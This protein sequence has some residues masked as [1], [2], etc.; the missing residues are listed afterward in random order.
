[1][2]SSSNNTPESPFPK[3]GFRCIIVLTPV[4]VAFLSI[5]NFSLTL[6][7]VVALAVTITFI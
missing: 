2:Y 4:P 7:L 5:N 3:K 1:M 6:S